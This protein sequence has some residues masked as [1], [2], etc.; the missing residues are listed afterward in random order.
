MEEIPD[1]SGNQ[2]AALWDEE[3]EKNLM[4]AAIARVKRRVDAEQFQLFDFY[5]LRQWPVMKVAQTFDV[6]VGKVYLVKHR[7]SKLIRREVEQLE[8]KTW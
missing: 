4:D 1:P 8:A 5:V 7:I 6:S 2:I 3:W